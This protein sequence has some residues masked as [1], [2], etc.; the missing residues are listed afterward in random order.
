[1]ALFLTIPPLPLGKKERACAVA[2]PVGKEPKYRITWASAV[3]GD[4]GVILTLQSA[5]SGRSWPSAF[6]PRARMGRKDPAMPH[7]ASCIVLWP[8][9]LR[10]TPIVSRRLDARVC[11]QRVGESNWY[12]VRRARYMSHGYTP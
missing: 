5:F 2:N 1:M 4:L 8:S 12:L 3:P 9:P 11:K 6:P 10:R 7:L